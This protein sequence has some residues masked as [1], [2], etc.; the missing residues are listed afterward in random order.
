MSN[1]NPRWTLCRKALG[2]D[3]K[4]YEFMIWISR[5]WR[6]FDEAHGLKGPMTAHYG[7]DAYVPHTLADHAAFDTWLPDNI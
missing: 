2:H 7:R 5:K 4:N 3:P 1:E 6:E